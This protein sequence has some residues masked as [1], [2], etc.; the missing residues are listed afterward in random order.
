MDAPRRQQWMHQGGTKRARRRHQGGTDEALR[1]H[2]GSKNE[3]PVRHQEEPGNHEESS[4]K[5]QICTK[6]VKD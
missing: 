3:K 4:K 5:A 6:L 2:Q 1:S